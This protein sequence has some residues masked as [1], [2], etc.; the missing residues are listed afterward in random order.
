MASAT[1]EQGMAVYKLRADLHSACMGLLGEMASDVDAI[2]AEL[3]KLLD[4]EDRR[5]SS[6]PHVGARE[7]MI[8]ALCLTA[9]YVA[10]R[11]RQAQKEASGG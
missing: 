4:A 9:E 5:V 1:R 10:A 7:G 8:E 3:R 11:L 2:E 6:V